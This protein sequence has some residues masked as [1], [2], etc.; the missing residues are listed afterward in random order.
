MVLLLLAKWQLLP[1][2]LRS[3]NRS[4]DFSYIIFERIRKQGYVSCLS[5]CR[6]TKFI[7]FNRDGHVFLPNGDVPRYH[8]PLFAIAI[9]DDCIFHVLAS[10]NREVCP[11]KQDRCFDHGIPR[12]N[13]NVSHLLCFLFVSSLFQTR[14]ELNKFLDFLAYESNI[15]DVEPRRE[16][17]PSLSRPF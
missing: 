1:L 17:H 8:V 7:S 4:G 10:S 13:D 9:N 2:Y 15:L 14:S 5:S 16:H 11:T 3:V 12:W 6:G